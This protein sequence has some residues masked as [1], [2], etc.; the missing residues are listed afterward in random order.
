MG[1]VEGTADQSVFGEI[2]YI[3]LMTIESGV[4]Y[5]G[6]RDVRKE[7]SCLFLERHD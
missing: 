4:Y 3:A 6:F 2:E 7:I 5:D 1:F